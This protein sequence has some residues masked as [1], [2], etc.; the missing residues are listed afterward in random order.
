[1]GSYPDMYLAPKPP[2]FKKAPPRPPVMPPNIAPR[3]GSLPCI[4]FTNA[5]SIAPPTIPPRKYPGRL[6]Y[7]PIPLAISDLRIKFLHQTL[8][9]GQKH[10]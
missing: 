4:L 7:A 8:S 2:G 3:V 5:P 6:A 10:Q 9:K 1:M